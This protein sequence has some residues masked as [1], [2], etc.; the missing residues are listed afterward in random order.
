MI[1]RILKWGGVLISILF[2]ACI[3]LSRSFM[4]IGF[5]VCAAYPILLFLIIRLSNGGIRFNANNTDLYPSLLTPF[6]FCSVTLCILAVIYINQIYSFSKQVS[7]SVFVMLVMFCLYYICISESEKKIEEKRS[8]R[9]LTVASVLFLM[10]LYGFGFSVSANIILDKSKP[11][12]FEVTVINQRI[13]KG[14][15]T[16][17]YLEVSLWIDGKTKQKE[18]SVGSTLYSE[19]E[20]G[21]MVKIKLYK[22]F[23]GVPWFKAVNIK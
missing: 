17:Y 12:V 21:N 6:C 1:A 3:F 19:V 5:I 11:T 23:L 9:M 15:R 22:G 8:T 2:I 7:V 4:H 10:F 14:K 13:L 20:L 16:N 18:I